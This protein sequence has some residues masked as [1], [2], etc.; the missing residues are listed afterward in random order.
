MTAENPPQIPVDPAPTAGRLWM[1]W[2]IAGTA[3]SAILFAII[4]SCNPAT[5]ATERAFAQ[6]QL[7]LSQQIDQSLHPLLAWASSWF[8]TNHLSASYVEFQAAGF[9][10]AL[11]TCLL[12]PLSSSAVSGLVA[13]PFFLLV[14]GT[15]G[16][17]RSTL[18][19]FGAH[20]LAADLGS[21]LVIAA[22]LAIPM[23]ALTAFGILVVLLP[24]I[25]VAAL[26]FLW[27]M[28][29]RS[30]DFGPL[31]MVFFAFPGIVFGGFLSATLAV[32]LSLYAYAYLVA[33]SI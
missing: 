25:R 27:V 18:Q 5:T 30:H 28:F 12:L 14:G 7:A 10:F 26:V 8:F 15:P 2:L 16:G 19:A 11:L 3:A 24:A 32:V 20:R 4:A 22:A 6:A 23:S 31:R 9:A 33:R 13:H 21:V 29:A 1:I 17:W